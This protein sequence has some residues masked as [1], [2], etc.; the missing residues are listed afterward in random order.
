MGLNVSCSEFLLSG[1]CSVETASEPFLQGLV[2]H[3]HVVGLERSEDTATS[4]GNA[5]TAIAVA[6]YQDA[7]KSQRGL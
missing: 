3:A 2:R 7:L 5:G 6:F 1:E 4:V